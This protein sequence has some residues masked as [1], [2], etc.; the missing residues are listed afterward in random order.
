MRKVS[1]IVHAHKVKA[2]TMIHIGSKDL[3]VPHHQ[4]TEYHLRLKANGVPTR[5]HIYDDNH[6]LG[7]VPNEF[8]HIIN[9]M[10]WISEHLKLDS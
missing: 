3:R 9:S 6:P 4:G 10:L 1:P 5:L 2:P 7:T 8:D